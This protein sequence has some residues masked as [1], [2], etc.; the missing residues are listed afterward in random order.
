MPLRLL[1][2][3]GL[4]RPPR[5]PQHR[6]SGPGHAPRLPRQCERASEAPCRADGRGREAVSQASR[7]S[8]TGPPAGSAVLDRRRPAQPDRAKD[9][10]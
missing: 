7:W 1:S 4:A 5:T 2:L 8:V 6:A 9:D 10:R 3:S